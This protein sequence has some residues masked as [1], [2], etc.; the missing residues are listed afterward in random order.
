MDKKMIED[1]G[2][3]FWGKDE[4]MK[5]IDDIENNTYALHI[6]YSSVTERFVE[7]FIWIQDPRIFKFNDIK[8]LQVLWQE[9]TTDIA[10]IFFS[11][12]DIEYE[13]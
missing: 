11:K 13:D 5:E 6:R 1:L 7:C 12:R 10:K 4:I 2:Y 3:Q 8:V 9:L